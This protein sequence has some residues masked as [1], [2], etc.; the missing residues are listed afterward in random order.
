MCPTGYSIR[1]I[2][3][4]PYFEIIGFPNTLP[5]KVKSEKPPRVQIT[6]HVHDGGR[7]RNMRPHT[8]QKLQ[9]IYLAHLT[10]VPDTSGAFATSVR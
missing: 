4:C 10:E 7:T 1:F 8:L 6:A 2:I 5:G 9:D 3:E